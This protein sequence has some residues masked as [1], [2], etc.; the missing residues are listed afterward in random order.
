[1]KAFAQ[2]LA[3]AAAVALMSALVPVATASADVA[4]VRRIACPSTAEVNR[5][6]QPSVLPKRQAVKLEATPTSCQYWAAQ[7]AAMFQVSVEPGVSTMKQAEDKARAAYPEEFQYLFRPQPL[8]ALGE[9]AFYNA[10][11]AVLVYW[12]LSPGAIVMMGGLDFVEGIVPVAK[13][14]RPMME[15]YTIPGERTVNGRQWRTTCEDYSATARCRT[16]IFATVIKKTP[17]GFETVKGW[18]FNSL[19][20]R[21]SDRALWKTNPLGHTGKWTSAE[22]RQWRTECDTPNT[23]RGACRS[24]ILTT[25]IDHKGGKYTQENTWVFNNQVLFNS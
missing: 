1:M 6:I 15:V 22:G 3:A 23:G 5:A 19:T 25:V 13:L 21:W 7:D 16:D 12:E 24:Y 2:V 11:L 14:F 9:G 18:A 20:Y 4:P 10:D 17:T 8:K